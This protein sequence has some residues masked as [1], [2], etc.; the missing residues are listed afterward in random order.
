MRTVSLMMVAL[1]LASVSAS[2]AV[3][4]DQSP[5]AQ[6]AE[7]EPV[8]A[9][10]DELHFETVLTTHG[11][12]VSF[13]RT[14]RLVTIKGPNGHTFSLEARNEKNLDAINTGDRVV[15]RYIEGIQIRKKKPGEVLPVATLK[16][17]I[18]ANL[19]GERRGTEFS[20]KRTLVASVE[21]IDEPEQEVTLR[22]PGGSLE[23]VMVE[24]PE[25]LEGIEVGDQIVITH[26]QA[27]ALTLDKES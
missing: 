6:P 12:I 14:N 2:R 21:A 20:R 1:L 8:G 19:P 17:G 10:T 25:A 9:P 27:L 5:A 23:T 7:A 4:A 13:D 18:A 11:E 16:E 3:A 15:V 22:G 24:N 26:S